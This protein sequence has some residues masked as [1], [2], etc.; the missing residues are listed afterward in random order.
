MY[1]S[2]QTK[3]ENNGRRIIN[4]DQNNDTEEDEDMAMMDLPDEMEYSLDKNK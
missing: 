4:L 3:T 2:F 1:N